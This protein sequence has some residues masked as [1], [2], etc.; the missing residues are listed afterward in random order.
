MAPEKIADEV[1]ARIDNDLYD[2]Q[3]YAWWRQDNALGLIR[4]SLNPVRLQFLDAV[5]ARRG[6]KPL[7]LRALEVGCG[8]GVLCEELAR[9][10][11]AVSGVDPS[12]IAIA[13][14]VEHAEGA[15]LDIRYRRG[16][17]E[18][19]PYPDNS[20]D[21]V[22]CCDVLEHVRDLPMVVSEMARVLKPGGIC[23]YDTINRTWLSNLVAIKIC[24]EWTP[25]AFTP[26][27]LHV[28]EMFVRPSEM[29]ALLA[30]NG[31]EWQEH[32]G[33]KP[34]LPPLSLLRHLRQRARGAMSFEELGSRVRLVFSRSLSLM[35]LGYA[36]KPATQKGA[37]ES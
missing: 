4:G 6:G 27:Q 31:L 9:L 19:L 29:K 3:G 15:G 32:R 30:E 24:Q 10:G 20:F 36:V 5:L 22:V 13:L 2:R 28:W 21:L 25:W 18:L 33:L 8:G 12:K 26:R 16:A 37:E 14:A 11:F 17:G 7:G 35:Y 1:Y 34:N 23:C